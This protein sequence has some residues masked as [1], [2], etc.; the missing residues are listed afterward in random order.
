MPCLIGK[1]PSAPFP[2]R[3]LTYGRGEPV[4]SPIAYH[5]QFNCVLCKN[6]GVD[7]LPPLRQ[8]LN[9]PSLHIFSQANNPITIKEVIKNG[10]L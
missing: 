7:S 10:N 4:R 1:A 2:V 3:S 8:V 9:P 5:A 6:W